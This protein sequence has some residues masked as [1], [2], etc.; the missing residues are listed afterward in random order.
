MRM[1]TRSF[2]LRVDGVVVTTLLQRQCGKICLIY[3]LMMSEK[4]LH[5]L[6]CCVTISDNSVLHQVRGQH[7]DLV[8]NGMEIAGGSVRVHDA[9]MQEYIF[10][11]I[12]KVGNI[13]ARVFF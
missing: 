3:I 4:C 7:Y 9:S 6:A 11:Q 10:T 8:L 1:T 12:L 2:W 5:H 13:S